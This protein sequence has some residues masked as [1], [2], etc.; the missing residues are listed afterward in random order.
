MYT[1]SLIQQIVEYL[2]DASIKKQNKNK[3]LPSRAYIL[4]TGRQK[5]HDNNNG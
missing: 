3:F 1:H 2:I 5:I 4:G